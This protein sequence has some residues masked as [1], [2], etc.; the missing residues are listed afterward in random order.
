M[1]GLL[2]MKKVFTGKK[3]FF[4][5]AAA[6]LLVAA[7][8]ALFKNVGGIQQPYDTPELIVS[9]MP[10]RP[11]VLM[12]GVDT[13]R[14]DHL[15]CYR[16]NRN[17]SPNLSQLAEEGTLFQNCIAPI[18]RTAQ[19]I[20]SLM[21]AR[22]PQSHG[23]RNLTETLSFDELTLAEILKAAGYKTLNVTASGFLYE[24]VAQ[25]FD[26]TY[27]TVYEFNS[28]KTTKLAKKAL[29]QNV[30]KGNPF[31]L[32]IFYRD[33][34]MPYSP[35]R[36][37]FDLSYRGPYRKALNFKK[38]KDEMVFSNKMTQRERQHVVALYDA[39]IYQTD[40]DI[41]QLIKY[42]KKKY[43]NTIIIFTADH[44]EA[45]GENNYFYEH[46]DVL[47]QAGLH[48]PLIIEGIRFPKKRILRIVRN[49][50]VVPTLLAA[51]GIRVPN[52]KFEGVDL[53]ELLKKPDKQLIAFSETG[54]AY[55]QMAFEKNKRA[56]KGIE[57]RLRSATYK[58]WR[59]IYFPT[60][61]GIKYELYDLQKDP[62]QIENLYPNPKVDFLFDALND[63]VS[64]PNQ[65]GSEKELTDE[66]RKQLKSLGYL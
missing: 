33:P 29:K 54:R 55:S 41:G 37:I 28:S 14:A 40:R 64:A 11:N 24:A 43:P 12:I 57:G 4:V 26:R 44:G 19:S 5:F 35:D 31:F 27:G 60:P 47:H 6:L 3:L 63:F 15:R 34:H 36:L 49:I 25:G 10:D 2:G 53:V 1:I 22:Y 20:A 62:L 58:N 16:Y 39:E 7:A 65:K 61:E 9:D 32:W 59:A 13:L 21:T 30:I 51:L 18:P 66:N 48:I 8:I 45:L 46:G 42:V 23:L 50:D 17:T 56:V 38:N 52:N